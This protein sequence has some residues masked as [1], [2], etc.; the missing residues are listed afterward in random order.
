MIK[1]VSSIVGGLLMVLHCFVKRFFIAQNL[2]QTFIY[3]KWDAIN[4]KLW[5]VGFLV[6]VE[7]VVRLTV[8]HVF[9]VGQVEGDIKEI[10]DFLI[11]IDSF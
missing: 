6:D 1:R 2:R 10:Y 3:R 9:T 7:W 5:V 8:G 4:E 11:C